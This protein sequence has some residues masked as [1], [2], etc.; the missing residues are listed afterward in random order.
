MVSLQLLRQVVLVLGLDYTSVSFDDLC[1]RALDHLA[2]S[3]IVVLLRHEKGDYILE[4]L[5]AG[6]VKKH[7]FA[8]AG[9]RN[10]VLRGGGPRHSNLLL[11]HLPGRRRSNLF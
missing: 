6:C 2:A 7:L 9:A 5:L 3:Y 4:L 1:L 11:F 10:L 8:A